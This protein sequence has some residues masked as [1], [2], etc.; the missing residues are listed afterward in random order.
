MLAGA[1]AGGIEPLV[2]FPFEYVKTVQQLHSESLAAAGTRSADTMRG[3]G[4]L[5][6]AR[7]AL[8]AQGSTGWKSLYRGVG[9]VST[10]GAAKA[11]VRFTTYDR[12]KNV[13]TAADGTL[14]GP[15]SLAGRHHKQCSL[16]SLYQ[17]QLMLAYLVSSLQLVSVR[18]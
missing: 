18:A 17:L 11:I 4:P 8:R 1:V 7:K 13:L 2:T 3:D 15:S 16:L 5:I 6:L 14:S 10:G 12:V 9:V